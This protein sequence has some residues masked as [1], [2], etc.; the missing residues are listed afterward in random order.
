MIIDNL[1]LTAIILVVAISAFLLGTRNKPRC[2]KERECLT[3]EKGDKN[4]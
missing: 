2:A 4:C 3:K 1:T